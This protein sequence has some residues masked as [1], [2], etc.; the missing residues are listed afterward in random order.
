MFEREQNIV[1]AV[2]LANHKGRASAWSNLFA[3]H[4]EPSVLTPAFAAGSA[5]NGAIL[6]W[7]GHPGPVIV[8]RD[9]A[10]IG[11]GT[12]GQ[13]ADPRALLGKVYNYEIQA[14]GDK[15]LGRKT[16]PKT[17][18]VEDRFPPAAP[19]G[20]NVVA[21][22]G[23]VELSWNPNPE[24]D[25]L[26]YTVQRAA[27]D[28]KFAA[29]ANQL[30]APAFTDRDVQRGARYRYMVAAIDLRKNQSVTSQEVEITVP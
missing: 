1:I 23:T 15:A 11:E 30:D 3:L 26:G 24:A 8:Y 6:T 5:P 22:A 19:T 21:G 14:R 12:N 7:S 9:G 13:F 2:R 29:V 25:I 16:G 20:L 4:I 27:G 10:A 18:T 17:L 28:G